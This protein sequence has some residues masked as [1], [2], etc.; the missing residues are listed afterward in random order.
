MEFSPAQ[1]LNHLRAELANYPP[2]TRYWIAYSG[3]CDS[4]VLLHGLA[5]LREVL[6]VELAAI[7]INHG[8][9]KLA[10]QWEQHCQ[11]VCADLGI[12]YRAVTVDA[13]AKAGQSPEEAARQA[14]YQAWRELLGQNEL[15]LLAHH[16]D[17]QAET[18][19]LQLLRGSGVKGASAMASQQTFA[20]GYLARPLLAFA[21]QQLQAYATQ[22]KLAFIND[23][24][25]FDTSFDRNF[26]RH[27]VVPVLKQRWPAYA[28]TFNRATAH[29]AEAEQL[30]SELAAQDWQQLAAGEQLAIPALLQLPSIARQRNVLRYW[31]HDVC[32][33]PYP[34]SNHLNR[35]LQ[36]VVPATEDANPEVNWTGGQVRRYQQKLYASREFPEE[37]AAQEL[38][39]VDFP[40]PLALND[41]QLLA[42][43]VQ[44]SGLSAAQL[45]GQAI[46][47][48]YRQ[49][50][51]TCKPT[52]RGQTHQLKKLFQEW[53]IPPWQRGGVPLLY[54]GENLVQVVG[55]CICE[56]YQAGEEEKG[57][58][59]SLN[60][61]RND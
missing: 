58:L 6:Q 60:P 2:V 33:L 21:R 61:P 16:Q 18:L 40:Q 7:H 45:A 54:I 19:L 15:L 56:P 55:Y 42:Q 53:G 27:E 49:G 23:P 30:L 28:K 31:L 4:H 35:I 24:S 34:D 37:P 51:E 29:F 25:N 43:A 50:G 12:T 14:R 26:L 59:I 32:G 22:K 44:G 17:D 8:L 20:H 1:L 10:P 5:T 36:E 11:Q 57:W 52:R 39:W 13:K 46:V 48:R 9:S 41:G 47:V 38:P 3:G